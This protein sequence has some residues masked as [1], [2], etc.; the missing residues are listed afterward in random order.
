MMNV[1]VNR[2][3]C[4][5]GEIINYHRACFASQKK[6]EN[7]T[8]EIGFPGFIT[9]IYIHKNFPLYGIWLHQLMGVALVGQ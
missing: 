9:N 3:S 6:N 7:K 1:G 2:A 4:A 5:Y 8:Q